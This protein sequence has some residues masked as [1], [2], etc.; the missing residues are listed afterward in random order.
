[1]EKSFSVSYNVFDG[2]ELLKDSILSIRDSVDYI[3][4][5]YQEISNFG[6]KC[7]DNLLPLLNELY[8]SKLIDKLYKYEPRLEITPHFNEVNKRNIG[9]FISMENYMDYHMSMD[10]DEFYLKDEFEF[11]KSKYVEEGLDSA[12]CQML[13]YYKNKNYILDPPEDYYV[14]LFYKVNEYYYYYFHAQSPVL[15][16]STRRMEPGKF[17]IFERNEIQMHHLSYVRNNIRSK[18]TNSSANKDFKDIDKTIEYFNNWNEGDDAMMMG[19]DIKM[20]KTK[21]VNYFND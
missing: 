11:M 6:N 9:Y 2:E 20:Y 16:D 15:V 5:V 1:M 17:K 7:S 18:F 13:T 12:Y 21:K 3:S 10:S 14:S 8:E 4:V 19:S